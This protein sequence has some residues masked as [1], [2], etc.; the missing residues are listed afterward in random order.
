MQYLHHL[1]DWSFNYFSLFFFHLFNNPEANEMIVGP[2][3][4]SNPRYVLCLQTLFVYMFYM[5]P[6][7]W[8][9]EYSVAELSVL[10]SYCTCFHCH[11]LVFIFKTCT[12]VSPF[13]F[14]LFNC[15][16]A[17]VTVVPHWYC[18]PAFTV[19]WQSN[20]IPAEKPRFDPSLWHMD[21]HGPRSHLVGRV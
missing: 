13:L 5:L 8:R 2:F 18:L 17:N 7:S 11:Y 9:F 1:L 21:S 20:G 16:Q 14:P 4:N 19:T 6:F 3:G 10:V 12:S 15:S